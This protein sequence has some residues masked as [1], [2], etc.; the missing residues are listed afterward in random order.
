VCMDARM[1]GGGRGACARAWGVSVGMSVAGPKQRPLAT[2]HTPLS[3][4]PPQPATQPACQALDQGIREGK[5]NYQQTG[6][7]MGAEKPLR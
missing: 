4:L 7:G 3:P 6:P 1:V 5:K 2:S